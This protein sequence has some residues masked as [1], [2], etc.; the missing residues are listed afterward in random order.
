MRLRRVNLGHVPLQPGE[1]VTIAHRYVRIRH[2]WPIRLSVLQLRRK[3]C[4]GGDAVDRLVGPEQTAR[5]RRV[6]RTRE[7]NTDLAVRIH[8]RSP[9]LLDRLRGAGRHAT[10]LIDNEVVLGGT[11]PRSRK[12]RRA[13]SH[14]SHHCDARLAPKC[15]RQ[16]CLPVVEL[17]LVILTPSTRDYKAEDIWYRTWYRTGMTSA[18]RR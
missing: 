3:P 5:E 17:Q 1:R 11:R 10:A 15:D 2:R 14:D 13:H 9:G 7:R 6:R 4:G 8:Q 18:D 12:R 16:P